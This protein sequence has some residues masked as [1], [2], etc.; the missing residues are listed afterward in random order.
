MGKL[1]NLSLKVPTEYEPRAFREIINAICN[2]SDVAD[3]G[4]VA[5]KYS[6][7]SLTPSGSVAAHAVSDIIYD[8][9]VTVMS[10]LTP[11]LPVSYV[12]LGWIWNVPGS[13]GTFQELRVPT[14]SVSTSVP[15]NV[16][17]AGDGAGGFKFRTLTGADV[18][19]VTGV[20]TAGTTAV[21]DPAATGAHTTA[22]GL[23]QSPDLVVWY[24]Q[25]KT[26]EF[27]YSTGDIVPAFSN[28]GV[29]SVAQDATNLTL[30]C[31]GTPNVLNKSTAAAATIT[32]NNWKFVAIPYKKS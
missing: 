26:G 3:E 32:L 10:S 5:A 22:H 17:L 6:A 16:A 9:N 25:N 11:G 30:L 15:N 13:P 7:S 23:G 24:L 18:A 12:R 21:V 14:G 20:L 29:W 28:N 8:Q 2:Q 19:G 1:G 27:G 4:K 31:S